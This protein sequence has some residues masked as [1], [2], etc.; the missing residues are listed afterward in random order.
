[1]SRDKKARSTNGENGRLPDGRFAQGNPGGPGNPHV[2]AVAAWR[3][4]LVAAVSAEDIQAV[5]AKL[6]AE[7]RKG[8]AWAVKELL[9]RCLGKP[10]LKVAVEAGP[11]IDDMIAMFDVDSEP[12]G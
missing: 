2:Q 1:M 8:T 11:T 12:N 9:D 7:A 3:A 4:A 5:I 10:D 6:V